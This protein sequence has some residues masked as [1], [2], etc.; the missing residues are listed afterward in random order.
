MELY[1]PTVT[2]IERNNARAP[3]IASLEGKTIGLLSNG[4]LNADS[5]LTATAKLFEEQY[6]CNTLPI[7]YKSNASA[8][9]PSS[10]LDEMAAS[11]DF[12][13][14]ANGD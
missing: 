4:K 7:F 11:V 1:D 9:A 10:T 3:A 2:R 13:L 5:W 6:G 14:T 12:M 8:P